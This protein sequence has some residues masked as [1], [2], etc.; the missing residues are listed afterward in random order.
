MGRLIRG[1]LLG[2]VAG[3]AGTTALNALAYA[4]MAVRGRPPSTTPEQSVERLAGTVGLSVPGPDE[5]RVH[6]TSGLGALLGM[7]TGTGV[8]ALAGVARAAG[9]RVP[10][11]VGAALTTTVAMLAANGPM[12]V[13]GVT[14]PRTWSPADWASDVVP[15]AGYGAVTALALRALLP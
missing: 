2:A 13:L 15:H 6:R 1:L 14:D 4:D 11:P 5:Q 3:A 12:T 8:G 9:L 7:V 10:L